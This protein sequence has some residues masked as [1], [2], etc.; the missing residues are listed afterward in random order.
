[1]EL[2]AIVLIPREK[3]HHLP[4]LFQQWGLGVLGDGKLLAKPPRPGSLQPRN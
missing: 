4:Q 2:Q 1:M 3:V